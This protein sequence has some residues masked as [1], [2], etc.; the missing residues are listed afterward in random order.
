MTSDTS[1]LAAQGEMGWGMIV[2]I[3]AGLVMIV[4]LLLVAQFFRLWL[5]AY[6]SKAGVTM[7]DLIG[8]RLRKVSASTIVL[9]KIQLVK[10]GIHEVTTNDLE[11]HYLAGGNVYHVS[12]AMISGN[13]ALIQM[14][15]NS[16]WHKDRAGRR[17]AAPATRPARPGAPRAAGLDATRRPADNDGDGFFAALDDLI[18]TGPTLTN[19][20]D[21][22][23]ILV[24]PPD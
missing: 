19:V 24:L 21:F 11:S 9:T 23:A 10:A 8:M 2:A 3:V 4:V 14:D 20:N 18:V 15:W 17:T 13:R 22:R 1:L 7:A 6:F 5:Q 12:R 16:A